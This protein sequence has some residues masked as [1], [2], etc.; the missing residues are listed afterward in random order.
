MEI[1]QKFNP[2]LS[3]IVDATRVDVW[4]WRDAEG[5]WMSEC[6][7]LAGT[8]TV[9]MRAKNIQEAKTDAIH[10]IASKIN[11]YK[12]GLHRD[13]KGNPLPVPWTEHVRECPE[14]GYT[15]SVSFS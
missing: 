10:A 5:A 1:V 8:L 15:F 2:V 14:D 4:V 13:A 9:S 11:E 7:N 12:N 6:P 3:S